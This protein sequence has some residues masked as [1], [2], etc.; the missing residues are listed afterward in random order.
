[1]HREPS[2]YVAWVQGAILLALC[3]G[4]AW[5]VIARV[6]RPFDR[7]TLDIQVSELQSQAAE[8]QLLADNSRSDLLSPGFVSQH[9]R[10]LA[11]KVATV[12]G[13][14]RKSAPP[15]LD[16][17]L[18]ASRTLGHSLRDALLRLS[19]DGAAREDY[20]FDRM[21][22]SLDAIHRQLKPADS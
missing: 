20:G 4:I 7:D 18:A 3:A 13:K 10:Q 15:E 1:V 2:R 6:Q 8:A 11:D 21:A 22:R 19:S 17:A 16:N 5:M 14:L 9:A 12:N